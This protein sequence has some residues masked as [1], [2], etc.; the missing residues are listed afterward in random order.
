MVQVASS[1]TIF[2]KLLI[3]RLGW[4]VKLARWRA[5]RGIRELLHSDQWH[6]ET[7]TLFLNW[8]ETRHFESEVTSAL[9]VLLVTDADRRPAFEDV[10]QRIQLP[11]LLSDLMLERM[12]GPGSVHAG[13]QW[14][15]EDPPADFVPG[16]YFSSHKTQDVPRILS[17]HFERLE[18]EHKL[19][20]TRQWAYEWKRVQERSSAPYSDYPYY[21]GDSLL[22]RQ[23]LHPQCITRQSEVLRSAYQRTLAHAVVSWRMPLRQA[24]FYITDVLPVLPGLFE[25]DPVPKPSWVGR[26]AGDCC[27]EGADLEA[28]AKTAIAASAVEGSDTLLAVVS[29]TPREIA[30]FGEVSLQSFFVPENFSLKPNHAFPELQEFVFPDEFSLRGDIRV[31]DLPRWQSEAGAG[32][33]MPTTFVAL[34]A[35][36]GTWHDE[37]ISSG[38][39][40]PCS[41]CFDGQ[42][43]LDADEGGLKVL[44][45][46]SLVAR[47]TF[48]QDAWTPINLPEG[49]TRVGVAS[50]IRS[51]ELRS[52]QARLKMRLAWQVRVTL[53]DTTNW[54]EA[55]K[56]ERTAFFVGI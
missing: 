34:P 56:K 31:P 45:E 37:Y 51:D 4:P 47:T 25:V 3:E 26:L 32:G 49:G 1:D 33:P 54:D 7:L 18:R 40:V 27:V 42:A 23:G 20:F 38:L 8:I 15:V 46:G 17:M 14:D 44:R 39:R 29:P 41:Y 36:H 24:A 6:R 12:Y 35:L 16:R 21:F 55:T 48:W 13:W 10:V 19:P 43:K 5:A 11:S 50:Y 30:E 53:Y 28:L 2:T 52:A 22:A 9:S